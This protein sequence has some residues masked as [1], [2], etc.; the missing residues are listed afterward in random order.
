MI[1]QM[2]DLLESSA[3][4]TDEQLA[5]RMA[6]IEKLRSTAFRHYN[7]NCT[8]TR[9]N[10]IYRFTSYRKIGGDDKSDASTRQS[11]WGPSQ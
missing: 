10:Y 1:T 6:D 7:N 2:H 3:N 4:R 5:K 9:V 8:T 11:E